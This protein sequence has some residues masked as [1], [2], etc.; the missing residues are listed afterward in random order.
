MSVIEDHALVSGSAVIGG[1]V[2]IVESTV[3]ALGAT[4]PSDCCVG[5]RAV[6]EA[7]AVAVRDVA[8]GVTVA[9]VP[10]RPRD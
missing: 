8:P 7:G 10:T 6:V 1:R 4:V 9:G 3:V 2:R 5:A